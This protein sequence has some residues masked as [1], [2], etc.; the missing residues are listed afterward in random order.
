MKLYY[1]LVLTLFIVGCTQTE[2]TCQDGS[3]V[4]DQTLCPESKIEEPRPEPFVEP[5]PII[6][7]PAQEISEP[8]DE[9]TR[10]IN[11]GKQVTNYKYSFIGTELSSRGKLEPLLS[12][13]M[14]VKDEKAKIVYVDNLRYATDMYY[15]EVYLN[16]EDAIGA[17]AKSKSCDYTLKYYPINHTIP[18]INPVQLLYNVPS[19]IEK[20]D[21]RPVD[22]RDTFVV[23]YTNNDGKYER[24]YI[25]TYYGIVVELVIFRMDNET[26]VV[27]QRYLF[28]NIGSSVKDSDVTLGAEYVAV[29]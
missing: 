27:L 3:I 22:G 25:D 4:Q 19:G 26:E 20:Y 14:Y 18:E 21:N 6:E 28:D 16:G 15:N 5:K 1:L 7:E 24:T 17:C 23:Q 8:T 9:I 10:L 13:T 12:Y 2:F 11:K 29:E